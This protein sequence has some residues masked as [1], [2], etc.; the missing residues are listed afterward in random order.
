MVEVCEQGRESKND[1]LEQS[2]EQ[3]KEVY[4]RA[5]GEFNKIVDASTV[6]SKLVSVLLISCRV[7]AVILMAASLTMVS[8]S[9][10]GMVPEGVLEGEEAVEE[11]GWTWWWCGWW[12]KRQEG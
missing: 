11:P 1:M 5:R 3:Y 2:I 8:R 10:V 6:G 4:I 12:S 7:L 9:V